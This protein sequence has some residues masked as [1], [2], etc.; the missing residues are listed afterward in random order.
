MPEIRR[1]MEL[2]Y[3]EVRQLIVECIGELADRQSQE[4]HWGGRQVRGEGFLPRVRK[5][6]GLHAT[7]DR[8]LVRFRLLPFPT[9]RDLD[10]YMNLFWAHPEPAARTIG[11]V[12]YNQ[13]EAEAIDDLCRI[14]REIFEELGAPGTGADYLGH[15]RWISAVNAAQHAYLLMLANDRRFSDLPALQ[16][17]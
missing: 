16:A 4:R 15:P 12:L 1:K 5:W 8:A 3:G 2:L 14:Y 13:E 7:K 9:L 10:Y 6:L 11:E 17:A